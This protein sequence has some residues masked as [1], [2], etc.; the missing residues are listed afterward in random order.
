MACAR[1]K[2]GLAIFAAGRQ[3]ALKKRRFSTQLNFVSVRVFFV[4][5]N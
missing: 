1:R 5:E 2:T 4:L 3:N